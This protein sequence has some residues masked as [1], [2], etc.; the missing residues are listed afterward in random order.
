MDI[1]LDAN[2]DITLDHRNDLP[3][4]SGRDAFEQALRVR[5]T[6]Y[7]SAVIGSATPQAAIPLLEVEARRVAADMDSLDVVQQTIIEPAEKAP[8]P[9]NVTVVYQTAGEFSFAVSE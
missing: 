9:L 7:F 3:V 4:V 2:F 1:G 8:N 6:A 5:L